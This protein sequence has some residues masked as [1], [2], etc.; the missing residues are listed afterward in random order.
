MAIAASTTGTGGGFL[1]SLVGGTGAMGQA[2]NQTWQSG[3]FMP[4][5]LNLP[6]ANLN[7]QNNTAT[8]SL[9]G[10]LGQMY[11]AQ[12][13]LGSNILGSG[14]LN[15]NPQA[16]G[17]LQGQYNSIYGNNPAT[18]GA[19]NSAANTQ[20]QNLQNAEAP[21]L[22]QQQASNLDSE[23]AKGTLASTAGQYQTAG[24]NQAAN[25]LM[26]QNANTA[27]Q[28]ALQQAGLGESEQSQAMQAAA[29]VGN[30]QEQ[31]SQFAPS[32]ATS[33][34]NS[35]FGNL[36]NTNSSL[37]QQI[38][39][40]ANIGGMQSTANT[41]ALQNNFTA[42]QAGLQSQSGFLNNLL[43]GGGSS[44]G[45]LLGSL[46]GGGSSS[47]GLLNNLAN[48]GLSSV[49]NSLFGPS[50]STMASGAANS[51]AGS[52]SG[53]SPALSDIG[54]DIGGDIGQSS[55]TADLGSFSSAGGQAAATGL[56][57]GA[58]GTTGAAAAPSLASIG[59]PTSGIGE[60]AIGAD[61]GSSGGA[62]GGLGAAAGG[63]AAGIGAFAADYAL[64]NELNSIFTGPND[65]W[66]I[67]QI[68]NL[69]N[70]AGQGNPN[71]LINTGG[72]I[73]QTNSQ[74]LTALQQLQDGYFG[75]ANNYVAQQLNAMGY[76]T[77]G[78]QISANG[79]YIPTPQGGYYRNQNQEMD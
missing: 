70:T 20:F 39:L 54:G 61:L 47:G 63:A 62:S 37:A 29:N 49:Y 78:Q 18:A 58:L 68:N 35:A 22:A 33:Q 55:L 53:Y 16:A 8:G 57:G 75:Q 17:Y 76:Q 19:I 65:N 36:N 14:M 40:G 42:S 52:L 41:N 45:G 34:L 79:G 56:G 27:Y 66:S 26:S 7:F 59:A 50:A 31:E 46:L 5:N 32:L 25:S 77:L 73:N 38:G 67:G 69:I 60:E 2:A 1:N 13:A 74:A 44:G 10:G 51:L 21:Y 11:N 15:Y 28:Q 43:F 48:Q 3:Q 4:Y 72:G 30:L 64:G 6:G 9:S 12:G 24:F 71:S 23:M